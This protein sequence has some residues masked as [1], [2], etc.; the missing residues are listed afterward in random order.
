MFYPKSPCCPDSMETNDTN[1]N[2][3]QIPDNSEK[4]LLDNIHALSFGAYD[5]MLFLDTHPNDEK[6][7]ELYT[8]LCASLASAT[9]DYEN[10]YGPLRASASKNQ[11]PF[12]WVAEDYDWPWA[13]R[14]DR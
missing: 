4:E 9:M 14:G 11:I 1:C 10:K 2:C 5:I 7:L 6:A 3:S 12:Q 8:Q 13:K